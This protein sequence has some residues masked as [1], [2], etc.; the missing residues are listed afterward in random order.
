MTRSVNPSRPAPRSSL[1]APDTPDA[2]HASDASDASAGSD[3]SSGGD[4][5]SRSG[6]SDAHDRPSESDGSG[7]AD[8]YG[9]RRGWLAVATVATGTFA[10]VTTEMLPVGL[11]TPISD[12]L[13]VSDGATGLVL[14]L[15]SVVAAIAA[16]AVLILAGRMDR[17]V[18]LAA[19]SV[20][21]VVAN[22]MAALAQNFAML[23]GA[24]VLVGLSIG[25]FWAIGASLAVRLVPAA[26]AGRATALIFGGVSVASV[27]GVPLGT[28]IGE[29]VG[30]RFAFGAMAAFSAL[31]A[32]A[33]FVFVPPLPAGRPAR[34]GEL[35]AVL[36]RG[37]VLAGTVA[38]VLVVAGHFGAYTYVRPVLERVGGLGPGSIGVLLLVYGTAGI[39]GN[40][41]VG[42]VVGR[43]PRV[44]LAGAAGL[45]AVAVFALAIAGTWTTGTAGAIVLWGLAYGAVPVALQSWL[46]RAAPDEPE[47]ASAVFVTGFQVAISA[48]SL[49]GGLAVDGVS[50]G[51]VLWFGGGLAAGAAL[52]VATAGRRGGARGSA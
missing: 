48:G 8:E 47:V 5:K 30:W 9:G 4:G 29:L 1:D 3:G 24:R 52:L 38:L 14:T 22:T 45:L 15:A 16:P 32:V 50:V 37:G 7:A 25:G 6:G 17:R 43:S 40:F 46:L 18:V 28:L 39:A 41:A 11:L 20:V 33:L 35:P 26:S 27:V 10:V 51:S 12:G 36:R 44:A 19:M 23:L 34:L 13:N 31:V 42:G 49:L 21:L 2:P